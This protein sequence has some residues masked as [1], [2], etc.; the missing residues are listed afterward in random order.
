[1]SLRTASLG[2]GVGPR[3]K[4]VLVVPRAG[5]WEEV[6][7]RDVADAA[8]DS[9]LTGIGNGALQGTRLALLADEGPILVI[10][11]WP[12]PVV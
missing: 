2:L 8:I 5:G 4:L 7:V 3:G 6:V 12:A 11:G 9:T 10:V 1:M